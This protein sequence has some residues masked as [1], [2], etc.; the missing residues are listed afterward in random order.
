[1]LIKVKPCLQTTLPARLVTFV[2]YPCDIC[3]ISSNDHSISFIIYAFQ[4]FKEFYIYFSGSSYNDKDIGQIILNQFKSEWDNLHRKY[5]TRYP[6]KIH[7]IFSHINDYIEMVEGGLFKRGN[8]QVTAAAHQ[9]LK[10]QMDKLKYWMRRV[11][12]EVE[13]EFTLI[14]L[15]L[16]F[17]LAF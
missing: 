4:I 13:S 12:S 10:A 7:I 1:M 16:T 11:G 6:L 8:D 2:E 3:G 9:L 14:F 5:G 15:E 17:L